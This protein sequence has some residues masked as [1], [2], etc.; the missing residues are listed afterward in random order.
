[1]IVFFKLG[2]DTVESSMYIVEQLE[3]F[4][5]VVKSPIDWEPARCICDFFLLRPFWI[6]DL[7]FSMNIVV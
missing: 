2:W 4:F 7:D 6:A 5:N 3:A 1:M